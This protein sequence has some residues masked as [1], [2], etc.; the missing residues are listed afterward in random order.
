MF[1]GR[2]FH[3][4][5]EWIIWYLHLTAFYSPISTELW[6]FIKPND[7]QFRRIHLIYLSSVD[8]RSN[9]ILVIVHSCKYDIICISHPHEPSIHCT[10]HTQPTQKQ[11]VFCIIDLVYISHYKLSKEI[12]SWDPIEIFNNPG[13]ICYIDYY[14]SFFFLMA[15]QFPL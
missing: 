7:P 3:F 10:Y 5:D 2:T 14:F 13:N 15:L 11:Y 1:V 6:L 4:S 12:F 8:T 9:Y